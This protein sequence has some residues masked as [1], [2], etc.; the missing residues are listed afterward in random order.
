MKFRIKQ[1]RNE[2]GLTQEDFGKRI[3]LSKS[4]ISNIENGTRNISA[5][6]IKLICS[7]FGVSERW[8]KTGVYESRRSNITDFSTDELLAELKRRCDL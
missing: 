2:L 3:G 8:L 5:R 6:H 1:L 4:G 7:E